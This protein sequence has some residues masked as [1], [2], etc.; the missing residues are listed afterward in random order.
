MDRFSAY[1]LIRRHLKRPASR[2]QALA[3]E[4]VMEEL[5]TRLGQS[6]ERWGV[7]GMLSQLDLEYAEHNPR[8]RGHVAAEQARLEGLDPGLAECLTRWIEPGAPDRTPLEQALAL[9]TWIAAAALEFRERHGG[10]GAGF[11]AEL[12]A[13]LAHD[14]RLRRQA[15]DPRGDLLD[16]AQQQLGLAEEEL[17]R[18]ALAGLRRVEQDLR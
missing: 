12:E 8:A 14:L 3:V 9:A 2:N 18:L 11:A 13:A 5:A 1:L 4:A 7:M 6:P 17:A 10:P 16:E 15:G